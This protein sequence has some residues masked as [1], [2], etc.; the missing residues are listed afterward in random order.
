MSADT[1]KIYL[2]CFAIK[3]LRMSENCINQLPIVNQ[4]R[5]GA[6]AQKPNMFKIDFQAFIY[7]LYIL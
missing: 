1:F 3:V 5:M 2:L 6:I 7:M 4:I